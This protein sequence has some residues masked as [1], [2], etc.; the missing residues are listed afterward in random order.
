MHTTP[1]PRQR[2][3]PCQ[4]C[5]VDLREKA[6]ATSVEGRGERRGLQR[7]LFHG[8]KWGSD[9]HHILTT[10]GN[11]QRQP[12]RHE[13]VRDIPGGGTLLARRGRNGASRYRTGR[14]RAARDRDNGC[15]RLIT[16]IA[17]EMHALLRY[18]VSGI[19]Y[20]I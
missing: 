4:W 17:V 9:Q 18:Q 16:Y 5:P 13:W 7:A 2:T 10:K 12:C 19:R 3:W 8:R 20:H 14:G 1:S 15:M 6:K 11:A